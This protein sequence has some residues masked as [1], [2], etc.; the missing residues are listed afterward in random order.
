MDLT[1]LI[2]LTG[3]S[4]F[5]TSRAFIPAFFTAVFLRYG[6]HFPWI[7]TMEFVQTTGAEPTWFT[8][9]YT[10]LALGVLSILEVGATKIPE[11]QEALDGVH[12]YAK[13]G[14]SA[15]AAMGVLGSRDIAFAEGMISQAG[16]F[17]MVVSAV[18]GG[19][20]F[21]F[22]TIRSGVMDLLAMSDPDDDLGI[23]GLISWFEDLWSSFGIFLL[24]L[25]PFVILTVL[26]V[27]LGLLFAMRKWAEYKEEKSR[28]PCTSCG[29]LVY[30][31]AVECPKCHTAVENPKDIGFFSQTVDRPAQPGK[32]QELRLVSKRRCAKCATRIEKR[33]LPQS[34]PVCEHSILSDRADQELYTAKVRNRLPKVLG[35]TFL[36]SLVPILGIIPGIIYYRIQLIAPFRAYIPASR[37]FVLRWVVRILF[38]LLISL[39]LIPG[40]GGFMVPIMALISYALYSGYF[41]KTLRE[42]SSPA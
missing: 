25:Y 4:G 41:N 40:L 24:I 30:A 42:G 13:T 14:L 38:L 36:L 29:E 12:K 32:E 5:F 37:G 8:N 6:E 18:V 23:R 2:Y 7:G 21:F 28:I 20:V 31:C 19:A 33:R 3:A 9:N 15:L 22:S 10:I 27:V 26:A 35:V 17:E 39:Q 1:S 34:C 11:A 16:V